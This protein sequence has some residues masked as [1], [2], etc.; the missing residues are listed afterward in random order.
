MH[1]DQSDLSQALHKKLQTESEQLV[2]RAQRA[3]LENHEKDQEIAI[4]KEELA[5]WKEAHDNLQG[6]FAKVRSRPP[7]S[8]SP[9]RLVGWL[10][11]IGQLV[12]GRQC[13]YVRGRRACFVEKRLWCAGDC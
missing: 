10:V 3:E 7:V 4:L 13:M 12:D 9:A 5:R 2:L 8:R 1:K 6:A 11:K